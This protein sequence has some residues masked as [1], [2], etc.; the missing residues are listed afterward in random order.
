[1]SHRCIHCGEWVGGMQVHTCPEGAFKWPTT[2][3]LAPHPPRYL[4]PEEI[5]QVRQIVREELER[6]AGGGSDE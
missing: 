5:E 2:P 4:S 1:M 6:A 3:P